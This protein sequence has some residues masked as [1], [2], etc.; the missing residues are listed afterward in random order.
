[1]VNLDFLF[2]YVQIFQT[3][4]TC[5]RKPLFVSIAAGV[6]AYMCVCVHVCV[7]VCVHITVCVCVNNEINVYTIMH[8]NNWIN[9]QREFCSTGDW[10]EGS[11][12]EHPLWAPAPGHSSLYIKRTRLQVHSMHV[13]GCV[14]ACLYV[15][16]CVCM[17]VCITVSDD[18]TF[19]SWTLWGHQV[20]C[21]LLLL[22]Y[23]QYL[24]DT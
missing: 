5:P 3:Y 18:A 21:Y 19:L 8:F 12:T 11:G 2:Y 4:H 10:P 9:G 13:C 24:T 17:C 23:L 20:P 22:F 14:G 16:V 6:C 1:M 15:C 7:C